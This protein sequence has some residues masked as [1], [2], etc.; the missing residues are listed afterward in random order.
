MTDMEEMD[1]IFRATD[2]SS[3]NPGLKTEWL[4][5]RFREKVEKQSQE[6]L[7]ERELTDDELSG[8]AAAGRPE[9]ILDI[10]NSKN[11]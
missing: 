7:E 8:L 2:F 3:E 5:Q 4:W 11:T 1:Q 9:T 6:A 10:L